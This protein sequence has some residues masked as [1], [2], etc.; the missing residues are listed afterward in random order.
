MTDVAPVDIGAPGQTPLIDV[1]GHFMPDVQLQALAEHAAH[2]PQFASIA[3]VLLGLP[4]AAA[5]RKL[6]HDRIAEMDDAGIDAQIIS[7]PPPGAALGSRT[8]ASLF[9]SRANDALVEGA[10]GHPGRFVVLASLPLPHVSESLAELERL[11]STALVRG[12]LVFANNSNWTL[13]EPQFE[14]LYQRLG[15]LGQPLF[16]HPPLEPLPPAYADW[17]LAHSLATMVATTLAALRLI[18]SGMLDRVPSL[19]VVVPHLGG[20][21]PYLR[22]RISDLSGRGQ[23]EHDLDHYCRHR[24]LYDSC[25]YHPPALHCAIATVGAERIMLGS[26]YPFRGPLNVCVHDVENASLADAQRKAI[27]GETAAQCFGLPLT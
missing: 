26:D 20:T 9:A 5:V 16:L 1:H 14:P 25:S 4:P 13:D 19:T 8:Q 6:D 21:M 24:L 15:E 17:G 18:F 11:S 23:A 3:G 22:Q 7:L 10:L 2:D 12:V 27:L